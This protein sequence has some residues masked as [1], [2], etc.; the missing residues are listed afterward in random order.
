[1]GHVTLT[2]PLL[3]GFVQF[4]LG[5]DV[6]YVYTKFNQSSFNLSKDMVGV[7]QILNGSRDLITPLS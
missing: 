6:A 7:R 3:R 4:V 1:M 2:T 5:L